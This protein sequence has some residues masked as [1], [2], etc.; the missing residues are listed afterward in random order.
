[1]SLMERPTVVCLCC[2]GSGRAPL[3]DV[4]WQTLEA[5]AALQPCTSLEVGRFIADDVKQGAVCNR[6]V[7][8]LGLGLVKRHKF[9]RE[10]IYSVVVTEV[11]P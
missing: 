2:E 6:L 4:L 1:M 11:K 10:Q 3:G 7:A 9:G 8:L 5:V